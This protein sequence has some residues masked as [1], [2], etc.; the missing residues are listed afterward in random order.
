MPARLADLIDDL[1]RLL[2]PGRFDDY[3]PNGLQFPGRQ[4]IST[5]VTAVSASVE[6]FHAA[7]GED[8][9]AVL[10]HHGLFWGAG[11]GPIDEPLKRRLEPLFA[12]DMS[13]LAY[14][15]PLDAHPEVGNNALLAAAIGA[16]DAGPFGDHRGAAIG[17]LA[18][19]PD[20]GIGAAELRERLAQATGRTPLHLDSGPDRVREVAI[21]SGAGAGHLP[22][23]IAAGVDAFITGEP[24]ERV[25]HE[26]REAAIHFLAGGHYAT[27]TFGVRR[28]GERLA[29]RFAVRHVFVDLPNPI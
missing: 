14:H 15:L 1:D 16:Q 7:A 22:E 27:E 20:G 23:A 8:A 13:L 12:R 2:E 21:V 26:A 24:A 29:E 25:L 3:G 17:R 19:F 6:L 11:P 18:G 5:V 28:L 10:V 9:D 4:E